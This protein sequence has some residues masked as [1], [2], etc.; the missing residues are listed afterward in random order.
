LACAAVAQ[1]ALARET[2]SMILQT[3]RHAAWPALFAC[4]FVAACSKTPGT[5]DAYINATIDS[6]GGP[7]PCNLTFTQVLLLGTTGLVSPTS[8]PAGANSSTINCTVSQAGDQYNLALSAGLP[9]GEE[10]VVIG[11]VDGKTGGTVTVQFVNQSIGT[12]AQSDCTLDYTYA[13]LPLPQGSTNIAPGE[14]FAHVTCPEAIDQGGQQ[15]ETADGGGVA[16]T[17]FGSADFVF[18]NCEQ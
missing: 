2:R 10:F 18:T 4:A 11:K 13:G 6:S 1:V 15:V 5:Q 17:C 16:E 7:G 14:I 12:F 9:G 8:V 3:L